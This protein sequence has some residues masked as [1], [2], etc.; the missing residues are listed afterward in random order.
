MASIVIVT[1]IRINTFK[2]G[3]LGDDTTC[4]LTTI[5]H[6]E[7]KLTIEADDGAMTLCW[8]LVETNVSII[9]ACLPLIRPFLARIIPGLCGGT[10]MQS[11]S[12]QLGP[13]ALKNTGGK[14]QCRNSH[15]PEKM[16]HRSWAGVETIISRLDGASSDQEYVHDVDIGEENAIRAHTNIEQTSGEAQSICGTDSLRRLTLPGVSGEPEGLPKGLPY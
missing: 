15:V 14:K 6:G 12:L 10:S 13:C 9:C 2:S 5:C 11:D 7:Q 16:R 4:K 3:G 1:I 8:T